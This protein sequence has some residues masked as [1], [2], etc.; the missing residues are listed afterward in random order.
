VITTSRAGEGTPIAHTVERAFHSTLAADVTHSE[1]HIVNV[2]ES[3]F[4]IREAGEEVSNEKQG[5]RALNLANLYVD[6]LC[7][8]KGDSSQTLSYNIRM[9]GREECLCD[10]AQ[11]L[12]IISHPPDRFDVTALPDALL[13]LC[14][15]NAEH[16][17]VPSS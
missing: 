12:D 17:D 15:L 5:R 10:L 13:H 16:F 2:L 4:I 14:D 9:D 3:D 8:C 11:T 7:F 6:K 1:L